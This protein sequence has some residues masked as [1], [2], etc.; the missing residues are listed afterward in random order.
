M[1]VRAYVRTYVRT[2]VRACVGA[3][4][5]MQ[6]SE[7]RTRTQAIKCQRYRRNVS[8]VAN[9][10]H[11]EQINTA[12]L[13]AINRDVGQGSIRFSLVNKWTRKPLAY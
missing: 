11:I 10:C 13:A 1:C 9:R 6:N 4:T 5:R 2:Y 8:G 12:S 7:I 3:C